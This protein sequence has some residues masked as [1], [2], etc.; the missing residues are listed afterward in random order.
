MFY[1]M[2]CEKAHIIYL[3]LIIMVINQ[4]VNILIDVGY[5]YGKTLSVMIHARMM[6]II[7]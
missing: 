1:W 6:S 4:Y 7:H 3:N 5:L 2:D